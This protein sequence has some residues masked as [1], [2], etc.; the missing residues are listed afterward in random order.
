MP[1]PEPQAQ[2][3]HP[4]VTTVTPSY[5]QARFLARA[6]ESVLA[7]DYPDIEYVVVDAAATD[8]SLGLWH[9]SESQA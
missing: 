1:K 8:G 4:L 2:G 9:P 7:Q 6:I 5:N 3:G